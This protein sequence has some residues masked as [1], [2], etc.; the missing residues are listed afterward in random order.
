MKT[1]EQ[2]KI[3]KN[4]S[5]K[6]PGFMTRDLPA[7]RAPVFAPAPEPATLYQALIQ[8]ARDPS[9]DVAKMHAAKD[10]LLQLESNEARKAFTRAFNALQFELPTID[11]DGR[12]D[13]G[14]GTTARG[15][16]KLKAMYSTYP[17][18]M[19]VCRPLL[20][21]HGFTFNNAIEPTTDQTKIIVVGYLTHVDGHAM[22]SEF[23][24]G[25]DA[26]PG[27]STAQA[28]GS[29]TS[30]GRRYNLILLLDIVSEAPQ[31][32]DDDGFSKKKNTDG[33]TTGIVLVS[34][35]QAISLRDAIEANGLNTKKFCE[36]YQIK[37]VIDLPAQTFEAAIMACKNYGTSR[38]TV[39]EG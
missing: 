36:K 1:K 18:L 27:R 24:L 4:P 35:D 20:K 25:A 33:D 7:N 16:R 31:D 34:D 8:I 15:N 3:L 21:A 17:N 30:Y 29:A 26:G 5:A 37:R 2:P 14:E 19:R 28:W 22:K 38:Q 23:P 9:A 11:K 32:A 13:H 10:L 39:R 12:I 6:Q